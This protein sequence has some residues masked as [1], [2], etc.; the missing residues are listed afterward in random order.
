MNF[1]PKLSLGLTRSTSIAAAFHKG[2]YAAGFRN[3]ATS[4]TTSVDASDKVAEQLAKYNMALVELPVYGKY[5]GPGHGDPSG[6]K[7]DDAVDAVCCT[8]DRCYSDGYLDCGCDC[9]LVRSM[10]AAI[11][12]TPSSSGKAAGT[13]ASALFALSPCTFPGPFGTRLPY[14]GGPGKCLLF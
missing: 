12:N 5:C 4:L 10:A 6:C 11:E 13:A 7:P 3:N 9:D 8:H 1:L 2:I 14:S